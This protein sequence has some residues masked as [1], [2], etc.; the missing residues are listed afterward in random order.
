MGRFDGVEALCNGT[1]WEGR[2]FTNE[3]AVPNFTTCFQHT[4]L[5]FT[6]CAFFWI[7]FPIF[8]MQLHQM[9]I[10]NTY[11]SLYWSL[12]LCVKLVRRHH[13]LFLSHLQTGMSL[14]VPICQSSRSAKDFCNALTIILAVIS[15]FLLGKAIY[16]SVSH[17]PVPTI[18][19]IYPIALVITMA[20]MSVCIL[21]AKNYGMVT[22]GILH[23]TWVIFLVCGAPEF[24]AW[25]QTLAKSK[26]CFSTFN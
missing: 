5:V 14:K 20:G 19:F 9:R 6:P 17:H 22:S 7:L 4:V 24:Y 8:L 26:V 15:L 3:S 11:A 2:S 23:L 13:Q 25:I 16:D 18:N 21:L 1:F 10:K 12:L